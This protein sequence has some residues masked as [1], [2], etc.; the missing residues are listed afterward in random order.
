[1]KKQIIKVLLIAA[2][3]CLVSNSTFGMFRR[4]LKKSTMTFSKFGNSK[5]G[6]KRNFSSGSGYGENVVDVFKGIIGGN[7]GLVGGTLVGGVV[8]QICGFGPRILGI[9]NAPE[10]FSDIGIV[11]GGVVGSIAVSAQAG[12]GVGIAAWLAFAG[13]C[14]T[15]KIY[16]KRDKNA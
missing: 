3:A 14:A 4:N 7:F 10:I 9:E 12:G 13:G 6:F 5:L 11:A 16:K 2:I 15:Y 8:G 1:M